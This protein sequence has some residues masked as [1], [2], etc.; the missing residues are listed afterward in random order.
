MSNSTLRERLRIDKKNYSMASRVIRDAIDRGLVQRLHAPAGECR[1]S[2]VFSTANSIPRGCNRPRRAI[3]CRA[4]VGCLGRMGRR[5]Q[6][7]GA[8]FRGVFTPGANGKSTA[9]LCKP[10]DGLMARRRIKN[11][12]EPTLGFA[13]GSR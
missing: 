7:Q 4:W 6:D 2:A 8:R 10:M 5:R 9:H 3:G 13:E 11:I 1:P 12:G